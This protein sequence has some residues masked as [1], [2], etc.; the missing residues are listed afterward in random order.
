MEL[1]VN[2][3]HFPK[4]MWVTLKKFHLERYIQLM[5]DG[6]ETPKIAVIAYTYFFVY[7]S[8]HSYEEGMHILSG[9]QIHETY[10]EAS[11][12]IDLST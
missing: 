8:P 10:R 1:Y 5:I 2:I 12:K 11:E 3:V 4:L 9:F 6:F 7:E